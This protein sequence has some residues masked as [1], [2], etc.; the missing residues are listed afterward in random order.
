MSI[1]LY[2]TYHPHNDRTAIQPSARGQSHLEK[3]SNMSLHGLFFCIRIYGFTDDRRSVAGIAN[4]KAKN[5]PLLAG[6][7]N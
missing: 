3:P 6:T 1:E 4:H 2:T 5:A 7:G